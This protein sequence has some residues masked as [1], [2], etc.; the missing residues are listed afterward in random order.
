MLVTLSVYVFVVPMTK[1]PLCDL[2]APRTGAPLTVVGSLAV[3][4]LVAPPPVSLAVLVT[5]GKAEVATLTLS[6]I[7]FPFAPA[8]MTVLEV[9]VT[10][11]PAALQ[12][13]PVPDDDL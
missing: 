7:G 11:W 9:Q 12:A 4:V 8:A 13:Q 2:F 5:L 1:L 6:V 10:I 3:A